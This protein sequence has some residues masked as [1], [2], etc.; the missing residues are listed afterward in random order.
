MIFDHICSFSYPIF[1][2]K[3]TKFAQNSLFNILFTVIKLKN[4]INILLK[5]KIHCFM[6]LFYI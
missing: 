2:K 4:L 3:T 1:E 5:I 6:Q